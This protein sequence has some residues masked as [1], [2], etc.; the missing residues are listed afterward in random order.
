MTLEDGLDALYKGQTNVAKMALQLQM[1]LEDLKVTFREY[2]SHRSIDPD[3]WESDVLL[4]W[5]YVT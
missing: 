3:I 5:P 1:P 4:G 2:V